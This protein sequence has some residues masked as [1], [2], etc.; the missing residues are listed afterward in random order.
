MEKHTLE[1]ETDYFSLL[2]L[3]WC[4]NRI[5]VKAFICPKCC[6][7][8]VSETD[9]LNYSRGA[10]ALTR[11][12]NRASVWPEFA[13]KNDQKQQ[14]QCKEHSTTC[15]EQEITQRYSKTT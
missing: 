14:I 2:G 7:V 9:V 6:Y 13:S 3:T 15:F 10:D 11:G 1:Y 5:V 8:C 12:E 4:N